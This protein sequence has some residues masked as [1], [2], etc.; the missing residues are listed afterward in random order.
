MRKQGFTVIEVLIVSVFLITAGIVLLLQLQRISTEDKNSQKRV[1]INAMYYSIEE[2]FYPAN[3]FYPESIDK[4]TL[5]TM[6][7][8]LLSDPDGLFIGDSQ[9][10]YRYEA[11]NCQAGQ[12]QAYTLRA[13]LD[14]EEDF[15]KTNR[16]NQ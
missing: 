4:D 10:A 14:D 8:A 9:S 1:A 5:T 16:K 6:D 13:L 7:P 2:S 11:T 15:V 12:C 3:N